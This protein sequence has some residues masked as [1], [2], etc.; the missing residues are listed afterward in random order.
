MLTVIVVRVRTAGGSLTLAT[1]SADQSL[2]VW[3]VRLDDPSEPWQL[4]TRL[5][6]GA[7]RLHANC[8]SHSTCR[9]IP[10]C[11][12]DECN[13]TGC[14][15]QE[16][17]GPVT[18]LATQQ[19]TDL[20]TLLISSAGDGQ[21][22]V[23]HCGREATWSLQQKVSFGIQLQLCADLCQLPHSPGWWVEAANLPVCNQ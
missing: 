18:S 17:E 6:V 16:H 19:L 12:N 11:C 9:Q 13:D 1:G 7:G 5:Q 15:P 3:R 23:W 14:C 10:C 8:G 4:V 21:V 22:C 20:S 2:I